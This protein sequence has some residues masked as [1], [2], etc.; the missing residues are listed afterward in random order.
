MARYKLQISNDN[1]QINIKPQIQ[2]SK[3]ILISK[4]P[5]PFPPPLK[6]GRG[7]RREGWNDLWVLVFGVL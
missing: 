1:L 3:Q 5:S 4:S 2:N 6:R 7:L